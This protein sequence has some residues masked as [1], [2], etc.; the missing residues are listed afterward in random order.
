MEVSP[1]QY[2]AVEHN[3]GMAIEHKSAGKYDSE[4]ERVAQPAGFAYVAPPAQ[5]SNQYGYWDHRGGQSF[6]VWLPQYLILRDLLYNRYYPPLTAGEYYDYHSTW[7]SGRTYYGL[8]AASGGT[9][10]PKYGSSGTHTQ[11]RYGDSTYARSGGYK[12]SRYANKGGGYKGSRYESG[13]SRSGESP[14]PRTFGRQGDSSK[15]GVP[16][17]SAAGRIILPG[18]RG[19]LRGARRRVV[20]VSAAAGEGSPLF[21]V[22]AAGLLMPLISYSSAFCLRRFSQATRPARLTSA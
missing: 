15:P 22:C 17:V 20:G 8:R 18:D 21:K 14:E 19:R 9:T 10:V 5:G 11:Q 4:A 7:R 13:S 2:Q 3:L 1:A 12:D 6:W 16:A